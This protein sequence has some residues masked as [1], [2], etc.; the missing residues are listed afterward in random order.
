[1]N[2]FFAVFDRE[3]HSEQ[4]NG[5][6]SEDCG[7]NPVEWPSGCYSRVS[8][9]TL[10]TPTIDRFIQKEVVSIVFV[11]GL[12][13]HPR[14]TWTYYPN[15]SE[16]D[17]P[18]TSGEV[19]KPKGLSRIL[20]HHH[21]KQTESDTETQ[22]GIFWPEDLLKE[23]FPKARIMTFG[24]NTLV[25]NGLHTVNQGN[26]FS[27]ARNL[28]YDLEAKR[29]KTPTRPLIFIAHSLGGIIVKEVLRRAEHDHDE[30]I[31]KIY[32]STTGV[33]FFGTPHR[34][35]KDWASSAQV[36]A[37][38]V[39]SIGLDVN[40]KILQALLPD[41][42]GLESCRETFSAQWKDRKDHMTVRSFQESKGVVSLSFG[43]MN[44]LVRMQNGSP[45]QC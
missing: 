36:A 27:H 42:E 38:I 39:S 34:G 25:Q 33:F 16:R 9:N 19:K 41:S 13:G 31:N 21:P 6:V 20:G 12:Q 5:Q 18:S 44:Q 43:R 4:K 45:F 29:R 8:Q 15:P 2:Q 11:H 23:D 22:D 7:V 10:A 32:L 3:N 1:M 40:S 30:K 14:N 35:S 26:L 17:K 28:L 37:R 24:Y